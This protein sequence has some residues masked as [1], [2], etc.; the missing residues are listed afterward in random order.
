MSKG[1][2]VTGPYAHRDGYRLVLHRGGEKTYSEVYG[3]KEKALEV[4]DDVEREIAAAR[5]A[6]FEEVIM[7]YEQHCRD[8]GN[9][10]GRSR[11]NKDSTVT[12][13]VDR[14]RSFFDR[15]GEEAP[16][17]RLTPAGA[18]RLYRGFCARDTQ[19]ARPP[20][21]AQQQ[22]AL[23]AAR[24][25]G[26]FCVKRKLWKDNPLTAVEM[27]GRPKAGEESKP[28]LRI[29]EAR[30]W[31]AAAV[32]LFEGGDAAALAAALCLLLGC[33]ASEIAKRQVRDAEDGGRYLMIPCSKS[34]SGRRRCEVPA[35]LA[36]QLGRQAAGRFGMAPLFEEPEE[37]PPRPISRFT[38][39]RAAR[40]VSRAAGVLEVCAHALRGTH[41]SLAVSAGQSAAVVAASLG[42]AGPAVLERHYAT[43]EAQATGRQ[44]RVI[45]L[46]GSPG[47][48]AQDVAQAGE[49]DGSA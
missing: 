41:A 49:E 11:G 18:E 19:Y 43:A 27:I 17:P 30:V 3:S 32:R 6:T 1:D 42:Q 47:N 48:V 40:R 45:G 31:L 44:G 13:E 12:T 39:R 25:F 9:R 23:K 35:L 46:I 36:A 29:D 4:R 21:D 2:R 28:Q 8:K 22:N 26:A 24:R 5:A 34:P 16:L 37:A 33:R 38:V 7:M 20:S 15:P 10:P 14:V